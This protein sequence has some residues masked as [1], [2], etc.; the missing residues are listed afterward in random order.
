MPTRLNLRTMDLGG[1]RDLVR[2]G[3]GSFIEFKR[4]AADPVKIMREVVAF[5]NHKG[6]YLIIGV[7]DD[8]SIPGLKYAEDEAFVLNEAIAT[9]CKPAIYYSLR[10]IKLTEKR[11]VLVY[12]VKEASRKPVFLLYNLKRKRGRAYIRVADKSVQA[13]RELR[14]VLKQQHSTTDRQIIYSEKERTI[15][16]C[17]DTQQQI[18]FK[19]FMEQSG[20]DRETVSAVLVNLTLANVLQ[21]HPHD[22]W[23][24]YTMISHS[25]NQE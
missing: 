11:K 10:K 18:S 16:R 21:L 22:G 24:H 8:G 7:D 6:G 3:E 9:Y 2:Q 14:Q 23:D 12:Q 4:K 17:F 25:E 5:A 19:M 1:L 15:L 13:S 20:F